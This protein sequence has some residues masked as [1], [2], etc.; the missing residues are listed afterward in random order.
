[1]KYW[2]AAGLTLAGALALSSA[3]QGEGAVGLAVLAGVP[4]LLAALF[5]VPLASAGRSRD[6]ACAGLMA[7]AVLGVLVTLLVASD[8]RYL[9]LGALLAGFALVAGWPVA[10]SAAC[11]MVIA[12]FRAARSEPRAGTRSEPRAGTRGGT[13]SGTRGG[14]LEAS[15]MRPAGLSWVGFG[16]SWVPAW[17][18]RPRAWGRMVWTSSLALAATYGFGLSHFDKGMSDVKDSVCRVT[19]GAADAPSGPGG[20]QSLLPLSDTTCGLDTV[21]G[22]VNPLLGALVALLVACLAGYGG[23]R[24]RASRPRPAA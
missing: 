17:A 18:A 10:A 6:L 2:I 20:G 24:L 14:T 7:A 13:R 16:V 22:F 21:P 5:V 11:L 8:S 15:A 12:T 1:M 19:L 3:V 9:A 23:A 4:G